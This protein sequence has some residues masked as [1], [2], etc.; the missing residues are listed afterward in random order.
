[1][2][3][4][5][6]EDIWREN[7]VDIQGWSKRAVERVFYSLAPSTSHSYNKVIG[8]FESF[9]DNAGYQFPPLGSAAIADFL[10]DVAS[11]STR[12]QSVLRNASAAL[13]HVYRIKGLENV[14]NSPPVQMLITGLVKSGTTAPMRRS[15]AMPVQ[16]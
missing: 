2:G 14:V 1:M 15:R 16:K 10:C 7:L 8:R 5:C 9:C 6:L 12:P 4:I 13:G 3:S 11:T